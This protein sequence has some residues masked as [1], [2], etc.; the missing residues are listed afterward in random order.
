MSCKEPEEIENASGVVSRKKKGSRVVSNRN[1]RGTWM[2]LIDPLP[3]PL[4][5]KLAPAIESQEVA[6][7]VSTDLDPSGRFGEEWLVL[8]STL[9]SVY[10]ANGHGFAPR[11]ELK[12]EE[13]KTASADGLVGGGALLATVNGKSIEV[14]RYSNAQQ[15][16]FGR[17]AKYINDVKRYASD[18]EKARHGEKDAAG[19]PI[20]A[21]REYPR[22]EPD[23]EDQKRCPTCKLLLPDGSNVCPACM[24]KGKAIRRMLA[25]LKPH[26]RQV[27]TIWAMMLVGLCFSLVPPYLTQPLTDQVLNPVQA[28]RPLDERLR[29][30]GWLVMTLLGVQFFGQALGVWRGRMAVRLGQQISHDLRN[31][32]FRHLQTLSLRYFD[33]RQPGALI[34]RVTNDT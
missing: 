5:E 25:Y 34:A 16:K 33:K 21:P 30:L 4:E 9:L 7:A 14:L 28:P 17:I 23:K 8:T 3:K 27:V 26:K 15:G 24:S 22:L 29:L 32:V 6:A 10:A 18:L 19:K 31:E 20:E 13:I 11:M 12:L 1:P 2:P